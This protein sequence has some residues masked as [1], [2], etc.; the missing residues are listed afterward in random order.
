M[1]FNRL[2][3]VFGAG[4]VIFAVRVEHKRA[5]EPKTGGIFIVNINESNGY[6]FHLIF[7]KIDS[8][9][10][11]ILSFGASMIFLFDINIISADGSSSNLA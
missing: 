5:A 8:R 6:V 7:W 11:S 3:S 1:F 9:S 2:D 10:C 4:R